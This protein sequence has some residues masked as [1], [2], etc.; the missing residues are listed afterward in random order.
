ME[1]ARQPAIQQGSVPRLTISTLD[2]LAEGYDMPEPVPEPT[3]CKYCGKQLTYY[4]LCS[5]VEPKHVIVWKSMPERCTCQEAQRFWKAWDEKEAVRKAQ[6]AAEKEKAEEMAKFSRLMEQSGMGARFQSRRFETYRRDTPE[7][8]RAWN[9]A[10]RYA[11]NFDRMR[12]KKKHGRYEAPPEIC[13]NG[14]FIAGSYGTGKTHLAAAIANQ[15]LDGGTA[16]ICMTMIDMLERIRRTYQAAGSEADEAMIL[17]Q[18]EQVPLLIID[19]IGSE[20]PTEWAV[21]KIFAIINARYEGY[22]PTIITTNYSGEE[23]VRRMTPEGGDDRNARKTLDRLKE[24]CV[25]IDMTW[26][27]WRER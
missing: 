12:P 18:Y 25:G 4:G 14:L 1:T 11:D 23:L 24:T 5:P 13:R 19:D 2:A 6:E 7:Q 20:Q 27:S 15:L 17:N 3:N 26:G 9:H 22:M 10:K 8:D 16:C 21:S